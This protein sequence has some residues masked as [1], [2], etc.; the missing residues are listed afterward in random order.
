MSV[1]A[2]VVSA[3][4]GNGKKIAMKKAVAMKTDDGKDVSMEAQG[5]YKMLKQSFSRMKKVLAISLAVL[6]VLSLTAVAASAQ[7]KGGH[8][9]GYGPGGIYN[10]PYQAGNQ[11]QNY[12]NPNEPNPAGY[13]YYEAHDTLNELLEM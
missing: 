2:A 3:E 6:F 4:N 5:S 10:T 1:T 13:V 7:G 9:V 11:K 12:A 8:G